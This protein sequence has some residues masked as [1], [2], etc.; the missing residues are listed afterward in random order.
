[1][2]GSATLT[3]PKSLNGSARAQS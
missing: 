3:T 2:S 1:M